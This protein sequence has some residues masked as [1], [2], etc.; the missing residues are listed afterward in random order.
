MAALN[1]YVHKKISLKKYQKMIELAQ[2]L[3]THKHITILQGYFF[4][5]LLHFKG[6]MILQVPT[7][8]PLHF[9]ISSQNVT[10]IASSSTGAC[11]TQHV[12]EACGQALP[13]KKDRLRIIQGVN[14]T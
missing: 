4:R 11:L 5:M 8:H 3:Q 7:D 12:C 9:N 13:E 1:Q 14:K 10:T 6:I 2:L